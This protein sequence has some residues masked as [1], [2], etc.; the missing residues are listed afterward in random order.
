MKT[1]RK[2]YSSEIA[3]TGQVSEHAPQERQVSASIT[4]FPSPSAIAFTGQSAAQAPQERHS[5]LIL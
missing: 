4:Y 3:P 2:N 1:T 5:S